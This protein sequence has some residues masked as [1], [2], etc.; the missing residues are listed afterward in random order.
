MKVLLLVDPHNPD[1]ATLSGFDKDF[2]NFLNIACR[3]TFENANMAIV[4]ERREP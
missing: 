2:A 1:T 4:F 3:S